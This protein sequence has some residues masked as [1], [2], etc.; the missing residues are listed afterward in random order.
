MKIGIAA[1]FLAMASLGGTPAHAQ[2]GEGVESPARPVLVP[3]DFDV[4][5]L[6]EA[7]G[8]TL[9]PLGPDLVQVDYDAYMSSIDHLQQTFSRSTAW[10]HENI[11]DEDAMRDMETEQAR[12]DAR[13]SFAYG[14]LTPDGSRER[15]SV[16]VRP[17]KVAGYDAVVMLWV[18]QA[19]YDAGFD[20]ALY[21]WVKGWVASEW[22]FENV[23][24][25]GRA[26]A[27]EEWDA[28]I[29]AAGE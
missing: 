1:C 8:F 26:I 15:G 13:E 3:A 17:S 10:P 18:T 14:V 12:F 9:V 29:A 27:W 28:M 5:V 25:P 6:V 23:A 4:P 22:P 20:G 16:Y 24:Y 2:S 19:D 7:D 11:S 21:E